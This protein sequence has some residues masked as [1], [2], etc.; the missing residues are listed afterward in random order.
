MAYMIWSSLKFVKKKN[1]NK[2]KTTKKQL[3]NIILN[4]KPHRNKCPSYAKKKKVAKSPP[5][6]NLINI[7]FFSS[8]KELWAGY[9]A[10]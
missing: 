10:I 3:E 2:L 6:K 9:I 5:L 8:K 1:E 7:F 4:S